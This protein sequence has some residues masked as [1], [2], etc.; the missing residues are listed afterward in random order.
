M[1]SD[2]RWK[3]MCETFREEM[4]AAEAGHNTLYDE[5]GRALTAQ[6]ASIWNTIMNVENRIVPEKR[7][8]FRAQEERPERIQGASY[9]FRG[10]PKPNPESIES[11]E[12]CK[13]IN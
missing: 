8:F 10:Q 1:S 2:K 4:D 3:E 13:Q 12:Y 9:G 5:E 11:I 6:G 7:T